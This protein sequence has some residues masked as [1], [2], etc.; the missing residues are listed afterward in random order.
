VC[1]CE[2]FTLYVYII[3]VD[4]SI[5]AAR[6]IK[7]NVCALCS[8]PYNI[9]PSAAAAAAA[10]TSLKYRSATV[11]KLTK[12]NNCI[13]IKLY[14]IIPTTLPWNSDRIRRPRLQYNLYCMPRYS[15]ERDYILRVHKTILSLLI[16]GILLLCIITG[17]VIIVILLSS[18]S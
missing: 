4:L 14:I 9:I 11:S 16:R 7:E 18:T 17:V 13:I 6:E 1:E 5:R 3:Y 2:Y 10:E 12:Y 15:G 8:R